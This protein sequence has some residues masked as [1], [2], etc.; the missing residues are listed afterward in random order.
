[1]MNFYDKIYTK[2]SSCKEYLDMAFPKIQQ[3][4]ENVS[5]SDKSIFQ[6]HDIEDN[7]NN[8]DD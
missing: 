8:G 5:Y 1:M 4:L 2:S 3:L 6:L 7:E